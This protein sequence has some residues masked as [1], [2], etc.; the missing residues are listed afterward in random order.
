MPGIAETLDSRP[1]FVGSL[2]SP[3]SA[4]FRQGQLGDQVGHRHSLVFDHEREHDAFHIPLSL[5]G[6]DTGHWSGAG[7]LA[8][9]LELGVEIVKDIAAGFAGRDAFLARLGPRLS[10]L[11]LLLGGGRQSAFGFRPAVA[12]APGAGRWAAS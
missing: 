9:T 10:L 1:H 11:S 6:V 5:D 12:S 4:H 3:S 2:S 8:P 7:A